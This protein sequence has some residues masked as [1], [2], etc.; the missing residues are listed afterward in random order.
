[1]KNILYF[2]AL[3]A[4]TFLINPFNSYASDNM[5]SS[6]VRQ[7]RRQNLNNQYYQNTQQQ[8]S[9]EENSSRQYDIYRAQPYSS[10]TYNI[11]T[12]TQPQQD[13]NENNPLPY[14]Q[15]NYRY[16]EQN[17][18]EEEK[19]EAVISGLYISPKVFLGFQNK[20][21]VFFYSDSVFDADYARR[22]SNS[23]P[24]GVAL[25]IGYDFG[26][27]FNSSSR[28]EFEYS[29]M[30]KVNQAKSILY[31]DDG[32]HEFISKEAS[33][34]TFL[35]NFYSDF[36]NPSAIAP[37][38]VTGFGGAWSELNNSKAIT[39]FGKNTAYAFNLGAGLTFEFTQRVSLDFGYRYLLIGIDEKVER[40]VTGSSN[41]PS[42]LDSDNTHVDSFSIIHM[43]KIMLSMNVYF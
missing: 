38:I 31:K 29:I 18:Q 25:A 42:W 15:N 9:T 27:N 40:I 32:N 21:H 23:N 7:E 37:Y 35:V 11:H 24:S 4:V 22:S 2:C 13:Y 8:E 41:L 26:K 33:L 6:Q 16:V 39:I 30:N 5:S 12:T 10:D 43:H 14:Y 3:L 20:D 36:K 17:V 28:L 1:M 19:K 34:S